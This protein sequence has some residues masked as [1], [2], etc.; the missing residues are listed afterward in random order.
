MGSNDAIL[1]SL[2]ENSDEV[3]LEISQT[4]IDIINNVL[5]EPNNLSFRTLNLSDTAFTK[6][7]EVCGAVECLFH[8]GFVEVSNLII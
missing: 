1:T 4:L 8:I 2:Q 5:S 6:F 3:F 7:L